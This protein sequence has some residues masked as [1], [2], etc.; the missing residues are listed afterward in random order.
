MNIDQLAANYDRAGFIRIEGLLNGAQI[1]EIRGELEQYIRDT[2]PSL[3]PGDVVFEADGRTVRNL[4]RMEHHSPYFA[5]LAADSRIRVLVAKL[6]HGEPVLMAVESFN[7]PAQV[8]SAVPPHQD[9]AYF[10]LAPPDVLTVWIAIDAVTAEN[11]PVYYVAGSHTRGTLPHVP[12]NV[13]GNSMGLPDAVD[14]STAQPALLAPGDAVIHH[15]NTIHF[16]GPNRSDR[17][18][19]ALLMVFRAAHC[20]P[21]P[22][23]KERY[24]SAQ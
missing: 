12:S 6:V 1:S 24:A 7:K 11:G 14:E 15:G 13:P 19:C 20:A 17:P 21:D 16:S 18:R 9:N 23:L 3:P 4:W 5:A 10:C 2:A 22:A 8:G